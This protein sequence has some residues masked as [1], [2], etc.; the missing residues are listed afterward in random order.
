MILWSSAFWTSWPLPWLSEIACSETGGF[1]GSWCGLLDSCT[2]YRCASVGGISGTAGFSSSPRRWKD[3]E[4]RDRFRQSHQ[5]SNPNVGNQ[6]I[7]ATPGGN[8][9]IHPS[10]K[11]KQSDNTF[12]AIAVLCAAVTLCYLDCFYSSPCSMNVLLYSM[13]GGGFFLLVTKFSLLYMFV[14]AH[15]QWLCW[16]CFLSVS[17]SIWAVRVTLGDCMC[18]WGGCDI[19]CGCGWTDCS[20]IYGMPRLQEKLSFEKTIGRKSGFLEDIPYSKM[21]YRKLMGFEVISGGH[22]P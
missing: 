22:L 15:T 12:G 17:L 13:F 14:T 11:Q 20:G 8:F 2:E 18:A 9:R 3:P 1:S 7:L 19:W 4:W 16:V 6:D 5:K 10:S 21:L